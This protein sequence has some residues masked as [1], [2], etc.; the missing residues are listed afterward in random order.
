MIITWTLLNLLFPVTAHAAVGGLRN[1]YNTCHLHAADD[2]DGLCLHAV[3][4]VI[5]VNN[6]HREVNV[7]PQ[8][9]E[10]SVAEHFEVRRHE[11]LR[12]EIESSDENLKTITQGQHS[13]GQWL[14]TFLSIMPHQAQCP[15]RKQ[16]YLPFYS[17]NKTPE[18]RH[19]NNINKNVSFHRHVSL[20]K[21]YQPESYHPCQRTCFL[22]L[23]MSHLHFNSDVCDSLSLLGRRD[24]LLYSGSRLVNSI[25][26]I[27]QANIVWLMKYWKT[28][29]SLLLILQ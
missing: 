4:R 27:H 2:I 22:S 28:Q 1:K 26:P 17:G 11:V 25:Y 14:P 7:H 29:K 5:H 16:W 15:T 21:P 19:W 13:L 9:A 3:A 10:I 12:Q 24:P 20:N 6:R 23:P 18:V 8:L